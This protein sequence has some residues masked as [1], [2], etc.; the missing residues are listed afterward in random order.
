MFCTLLLSAKRVAFEI[1]LSILTFQ[2]I[3]YARKNTLQCLSTVRYY[4]AKFRKI[5]P[6]L[7]K[8]LDNNKILL[9]I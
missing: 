5:F 7:L 3:N 9:L 4:M 6:K 1:F 8:E 2:C